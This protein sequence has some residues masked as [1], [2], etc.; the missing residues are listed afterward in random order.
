MRLPS[1]LGTPSLHGLSAQVTCITLD[2]MSGH[3]STAPC[4]S[5]LLFSSAHPYLSLPKHLTVTVKIDADFSSS[6]NC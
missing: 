2:S 6:L 5:V 4:P 1:L 3:N